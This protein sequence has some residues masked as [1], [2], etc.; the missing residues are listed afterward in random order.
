MLLADRR[1]P[2]QAYPLMTDGGSIVTLT[3]LGS[4]RVTPFYNVMGGGEGRA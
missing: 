1:V 4:N 2:P 3:Y